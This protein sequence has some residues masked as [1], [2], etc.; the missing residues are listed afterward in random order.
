MVNYSRELAEMDRE[1]AARLARTP[2]AVS[3]LKPL[4]DAYLQ[5]YDAFGSRHPGA[6]DLL[7][8]SDAVSDE[9]W[10]GR[11]VPQDFAAEVLRL[12]EVSR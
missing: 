8:V 6:V 9:M 4:C 10:E 5:L 11:D 2:H 12:L 7:Q 1:Q 3:L